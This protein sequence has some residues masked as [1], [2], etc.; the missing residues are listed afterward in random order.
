MWAADLPGSLPARLGFEPCAAYRQGS[1]VDGRGSRDGAE[2]RGLVGR[3]HVRLVRTSARCRVSG[4]AR[5]GYGEYQGS[6]A[7]L[8]GVQ[9]SHGQAAGQAAR[10]R[11]L[12]A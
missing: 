1:V 3:R 7:G 12:R 9:R 8:P 4:T 11:T 2:R 6:G 10:R 5:V